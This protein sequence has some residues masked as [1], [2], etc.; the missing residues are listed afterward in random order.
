MK[1]LLE[2]NGIKIQFIEIE[3]EELREMTQDDGRRQCWNTTNQLPKLLISIEDGTLVV[4]TMWANSISW[5][6]VK[7]AKS[8]APPQGN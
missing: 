3:M 5:D 4:L 2:G 8:K 7:K 1:E 6:L